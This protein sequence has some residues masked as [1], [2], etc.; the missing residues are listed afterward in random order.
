MAKKTDNDFSQED[1]QK[2][3]DTR[4]EMLSHLIV[5]QLKLILDGL[6]DAALIPISLLAGLGGFFFRQDDPWLWYRE[7]L[8]WGRATDHWIDLFDAH[9][10]D[11]PP[12]FEEMVAATKQKLET[13]ELSESDEHK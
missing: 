8:S 2:H 1:Q 10:D 11:E 5:F 6:R 7:V 3:D 4:W 12:N 9:K 13:A